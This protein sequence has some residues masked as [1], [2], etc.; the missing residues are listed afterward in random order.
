[1]ALQP[2]ETVQ[3][4]SG[5]PL[6]TVVKVED[7]RVTCMWYAQDFGEYRTHVFEPAW[8]EAIDLEDDEDDE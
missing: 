6:M 3:L 5:G 7:K 1:M 8:L 4:K 2:G